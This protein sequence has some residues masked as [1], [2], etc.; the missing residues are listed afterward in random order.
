M[1][2]SDAPLTQRE[3]NERAEALHR[4]A[5]EDHIIAIRKD[6]DAKRQPRQREPITP[7]AGVTARKADALMG[8]ARAPV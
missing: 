1:T 6:F 5:L 4:K 8:A 7:R 2:L 3:I